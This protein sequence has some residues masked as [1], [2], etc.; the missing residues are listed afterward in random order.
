LKIGTWNELYLYQPGD[1]KMFLGQLYRYKPDIT[2]IQEIRWVGE[3][4]KEKKDHF[5]FTA[6]KGEITYVEQ[7]LLNLRG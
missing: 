4:V 2:A 3:G 7:D 5:V 1:L 6:V